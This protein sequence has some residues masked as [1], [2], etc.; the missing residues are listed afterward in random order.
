MKVDITNIL[1]KSDQFTSY[2]NSLSIKVFSIE[3]NKRNQYLRLYSDYCRMAFVLKFIQ[4]RLKKLAFLKMEVKFDWSAE[5]P[6]IL[7]RL[8]QMENE[9][10]EGIEPRA[11][12][13]VIK[14]AN[15][16]KN[17]TKTK[18]DIKNVKLNKV[19]KRDV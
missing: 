15:L 7:K 2:A 19:V 1:L 14:K 6:G 18:I 17:S 3:N 8:S 9:L 11:K 10:F 12:K 13:M 4:W 5:I 16:E